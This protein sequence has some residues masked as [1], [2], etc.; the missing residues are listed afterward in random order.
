[1]DLLHDPW[2]ELE[3]FYISAYLISHIYQLLACFI[4]LQTSTVPHIRTEM[5]SVS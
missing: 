2:Y 4:L 3:Q 1:M 5:S